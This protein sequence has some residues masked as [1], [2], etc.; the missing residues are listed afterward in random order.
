MTGGASWTLTVVAVLDAT[1]KPAKLVYLQRW[2][3]T[4]WE[5]Q[6]KDVAAI[7]ARFQPWR[8]LADGNSIGD[9]LAETLQTEV[10]AAVNAAT[11]GRVPT[12]ERFTFGAES[13]AKLIDRLTLGLS[14]RAV[15]YPAHRVLLSELRAFEYGAV[16]GSGRAK[17][18]ARSGAHDDVVIALALAWFAA[19]EGAPA[20]LRERMML[21]S[22]IGAGRR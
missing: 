20:P 8:V 3:G 11:G 17:M 18:G 9:P 22:Q 13:K 2:Q 4:G 16:G 15:Q 14:G 21:G 1:V 12:V 5:T 7:V 10:R 6:A 19:P